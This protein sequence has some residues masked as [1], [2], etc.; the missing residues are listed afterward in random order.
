MK[1]K[2]YYRCEFVPRQ[3]G[4]TQAVG[5]ICTEGFESVRQK[6]IKESEANPESVVCIMERTL[7]AHV[8]IVPIDQH[9]ETIC[10][11]SERIDS[12]IDGV[13]DGIYRPPGDEE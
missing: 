2:I 8:S 9:G 4:S 13:G 3:G 10:W 6:I 11:S 12:F 1:D 7:T 5:V